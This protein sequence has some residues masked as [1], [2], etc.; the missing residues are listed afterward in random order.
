MFNA[1]IEYSRACWATGRR[2]T[3][4]A[5]PANNDTLLKDIDVQDVLMVV[6]VRGKDKS[7]DVGTLFGKPFYLR[8]PG[9]SPSQAQ[10]RPKP[11]KRAQPDVLPGPSPSKPGPSHG[12][13]ARPGP[14]H[15]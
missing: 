6:G 7:L 14:M 1:V 2:R 9:P 13:Q 5:T 3:Q 10:A 12:F 4:G 8:G 15:H 11:S